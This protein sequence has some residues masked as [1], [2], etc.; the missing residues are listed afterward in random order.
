M[1]IVEASPIKHIILL[2]FAVAAFSGCASNRLSS[3]VKPYVGRDINELIAR[4]GKPTGKLEKTGDRVLVWSTDSEGV[5]PTGSSA[6]GAST[7]I[8]TVHHECTLEVTISAEN[9][10]LS[11]EVEGSDAGCS[12]FLSHLW[13]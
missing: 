7:R 12:S 13:H 11:Y 8:E 6:D 5:L 3:H 10:V 9:V 2:A 1:R 4:L